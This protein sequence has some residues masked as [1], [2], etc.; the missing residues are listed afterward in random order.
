MLVLDA[1]S[2]MTGRTHDR[3]SPRRMDANPQ[4][5]AHPGAAEAGPRRARC[6]P[7]CSSSPA[8][9]MARWSRPASA[10][11]RGARAIT[12][13]TTRSSACGAF[14]ELCGAAAAVRASAPFGGQILSHDFVEAALMRRAAGRSGSPTTWPAA[15]RSRRPRI[16][17][18]RRPR[19]PLVPGQ[20]AAHPRARSPRACTGSAGCIS[21]SASCPT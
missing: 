8:R 3:R 13:A 15:T 16:D 19:P 2:L 9:S 17:R 12:G 14:A 5:R 4:R 7:A 1:D 11:G 21:A 10:A 18:L 20:P 6:S